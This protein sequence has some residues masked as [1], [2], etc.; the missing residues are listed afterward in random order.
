M[1]NFDPFSFFLVKYVSQGVR[2]SVDIALKNPLRPCAFQQ[3]RLY[4][5]QI[6]TQ[7]SSVDI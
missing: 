3:S 1:Y 7:S 6:N 2:E 4:V 5:M